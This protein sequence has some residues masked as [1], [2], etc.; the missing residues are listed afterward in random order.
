MSEDTHPGAETTLKKWTSQDTYP[1]G[2]Y[3]AEERSVYGYSSRDEDTA[4]ERVSQDSHIR[5]GD[6]I[7]NRGWLMILI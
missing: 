3:T 1:R 2:G 6:N 4:E 7:L 5:G